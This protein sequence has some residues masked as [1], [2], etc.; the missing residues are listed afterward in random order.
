M[1]D[2]ANR[3]DALEEALVTL[4]A[5]EAARVFDPTPFDAEALVTAPKV[6]ALPVTRRRIGLIWVP[7]AAAA[8][9]A[10][11]VWSWMFQSQLSSLRLAGQINP[12]EVIVG[13]PASGE[14]GCA[15]NFTDCF[16]GP[17]PEALAR[18]ESCDYDADGDVDMFDYR[19]YQAT[20]GGPTRLR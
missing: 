6:R 3:L 14:S 4:H 16:G 12:S 19:A 7:F 5:M 17:H 8:V 10:V 15:G 13:G 18:C 2:D 11:G 1:V 20:Y 9:L